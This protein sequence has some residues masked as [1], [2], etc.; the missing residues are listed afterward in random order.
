VSQKSVKKLVL[1]PAL[2]KEEVLYY[3]QNVDQIE[4]PDSGILHPTLM[5]VEHHPLNRIESLLNPKMVYRT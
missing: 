1:A 3:T 2:L 5:N 4:Y